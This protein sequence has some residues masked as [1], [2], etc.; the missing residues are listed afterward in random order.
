MACIYYIYILYYYILYIYA[1]TNRLY[2]H[3]LMLCQYL[4]YI[5]VHPIRRKC[6]CLHIYICVCV[7]LIYIYMHIISAYIYIYLLYVADVIRSR[8]F[9]TARSLR[10][11]RCCRWW[12]RRSPQ[13][14][15]FMR[16]LAESAMGQIKWQ[17][18]WRGTGI[19]KECLRRLQLCL[20]H[21]FSLILNEFQ[22]WFLEF[23]EGQI[24]RKTF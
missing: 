17:R 16:P 22:G 18:E 13:W 6:I 23:V 24:F 20:F 8:F 15:G 5:H 4:L 11:Q 14:N 2:T 21:H 7:C 3:F 12:H 9:Q 1:N 19:A 10:S